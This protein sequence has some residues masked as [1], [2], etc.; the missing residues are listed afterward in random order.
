MAKS[1]EDRVYERLREALSLPYELFPNVRW[2]SKPERNSPAP[3]HRP[4]WSSRQQHGLLI[5]KTK[6]GRIRRDG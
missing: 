6:G 1:A 2:I 4:T 3:T 5:V